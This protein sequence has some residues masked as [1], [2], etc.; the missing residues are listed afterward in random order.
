[1]YTIDIVD[2]YEVP[3][4]PLNKVAESY[5]KQYNTINVDPGTQTDCDN[6]NGSLPSN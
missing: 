3:E 6:Y 4:G 2:N 1:M 5:M